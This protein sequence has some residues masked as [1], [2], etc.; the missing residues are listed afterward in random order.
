MQWIWLNPAEALEVIRSAVE[1]DVPLDRADAAILIL[2]LR[3]HDEQ[4]MRSCQFFFVTD[5][6]S[7]RWSDSH[8]TV[9][10]QWALQYLPT[11]S[12]NTSFDDGVEK[13]L[14]QDTY[15]GAPVNIFF[16]NWGP[17]YRICDQGE[18]AFPATSLC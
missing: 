10:G 4:W 9:G 2:G 17:R 1:H 13:R 11:H 8:E 15:V 5:H 14:T 6:A 12:S 3:S 18:R 16:F 7:T